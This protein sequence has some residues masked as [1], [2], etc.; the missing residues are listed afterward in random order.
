MRRVG[1][2]WTDGKYLR[3]SRETEKQYGGGKNPK[4][5]TRFC[6]LFGFRTRVSRNFDSSNADTTVL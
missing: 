1:T 6:M 4:I 3:R 2:R 5:R